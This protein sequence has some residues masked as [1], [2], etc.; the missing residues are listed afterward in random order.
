MLQRITLRVPWV[1]ITI[2]VNTAHDRTA[3]SL[4]PEPYHPQLR[5]FSDRT[6]VKVRLAELTFCDTHATPK[7]VVFRSAVGLATLEDESSLPRDAL[8]YLLPRS[9]RSDGPS[10]HGP[11][12]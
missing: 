10:G 6:V 3:P 7:F 12:R 1:S 2:A 5:G 4:F 8:R 11:D 9:R